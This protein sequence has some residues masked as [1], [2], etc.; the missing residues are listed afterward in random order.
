MTSK[1]IVAKDNQLTQMASYDLSV[2]EQRL[3]LLCLAKWDSRIRAPIDY[4]VTVSV[5]DF[6]TELN[7]EKDNAYRDL[8]KAAIKLYNRNIHI[9][10]EIDGSNARWIYKEE[11]TKIKGEVILYFSP[12]IIPYIS[13]LKEKFTRYKLKDV[14]QFK[15]SYSFR[16]YELL[17]SWNCK[18]ELTVDVTWIRSALQLGK[19]YKTT[20]DLKKFVVL[21]AVKDINQFSNLSVTFD[22]EKR[23]KEIIRFV[24]KYSVKKEANNKPKPKR[25]KPI[26]QLFTGHK[27]GPKVDNDAHFADLEK[28]Y[29]AAWEKITTLSGD[30]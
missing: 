24:F 21:P 1:L 20:S 15:S 2:I 5:D 4:G 30:A 18:N 16:F 8:V 9:G 28:R 27:D 26:V 25:T 10:N 11:H 12:E 13:E 17:V 14:S 6:Y 29:P 19:K 3:I 23:G 7:I 22:Q